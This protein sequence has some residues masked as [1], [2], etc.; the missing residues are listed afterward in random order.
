MIEP[1]APFWSDWM[2]AALVAT[3][4]AL[5]FGRVALTLFR[6]RRGG[7]ELTAAVRAVALEEPTGADR[8][9]TIAAKSPPAIAAGAAHWLA[10]IADGRGDFASALAA[11][12]AG[13][14]KISTRPLEAATSDWVLPELWSDRAFAKLL[15]GRRDEALA[16]MVVLAERFPSFP[17][18]ARASF[19]VELVDRLRRGDVASAAELAAGARDVPITPRVEL[20]ADLA[21]AVADPATPE[22][23]RTRIHTELRADEPSARW[24]RLVAPDAIAAFQRSPDPTPDEERDA[25][26]E[27]ESL[28]EAEAAE[29]LAA[30]RV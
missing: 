4:L 14:P 21:R 19:R 1:D 18:H 27:A 10:E 13:S 16:E 15:L 5:F 30:R 12:E 11:A 17:F 24:I 8:I 6:A 22:I 7:R 26:A 23:E 3:F 9:A 29:P 28:A 2:T 25:A 20:L